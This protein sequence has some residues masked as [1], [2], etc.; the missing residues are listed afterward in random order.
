LEEILADKPSGPGPIEAQ[1]VEEHFRKLLTAELKD[2]KAFLEALP[3]ITKLMDNE[4]FMA[5]VEKEEVI[6]HIK[7]TAQT[8]AKGLTPFGQLGNRAAMLWGFIVMWLRTG[9]LPGTLLE[10]IGIVK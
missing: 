6:R 7:L 10:S 5:K 4:G 1:K 3:S 2:A 8:A 9:Y